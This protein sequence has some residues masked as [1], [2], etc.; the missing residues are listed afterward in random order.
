MVGRLG[1]PRCIKGPPVLAVAAPARP[2]WPVINDAPVDG[3]TVP[4]WQGPR[5][6]EGQGQGQREGQGEGQGTPGRRRGR[7]RGG[8]EAGQGQGQG[9]G[10]A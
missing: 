6:G 7:R 3:L 8:R 4:R 5:Q 10:E 1:S 9:Q 2:A